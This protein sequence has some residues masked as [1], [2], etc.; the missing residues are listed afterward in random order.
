MSSVDY[1]VV[2]PMCVDGAN[3]PA[4]CRQNL[5]AGYLNQIQ[6]QTWNSACGQTPDPELDLVQVISE[7]QNTTIG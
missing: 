2:D 1:G 5:S 7:W 3:L 4:G 6:V